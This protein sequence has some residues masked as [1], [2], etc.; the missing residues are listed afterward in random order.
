MRISRVIVSSDS[1]RDY[2]EFWPIVARTWSL[3]GVTPTLAYTDADDSVV[4]YSVGDVVRIPCIKGVDSVFAAQCARLLVPA[5]YPD[6][7]CLISDID[8]LPLSIDFFQ[9]PIASLKDESF[10]IYRSRACP[11][12]QIAVCWNAALGATWGEMFAVGNMDD[13]VRTLME[14]TPAVYRFAGAGW[15]TDQ[16]MLRRYVERFRETN[17]ARV[18]ELDDLQTGFRRL[19]RLADDQDHSTRFEMGKFYSDF[20]MPRP[21]SE[22]KGLINAVVGLHFR[23]RIKPSRR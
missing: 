21:Y 22:H 2:I 10:V 16:V 7:V 4:D 1:N 18:I 12:D 5:F 9:S 14:W 19:D 3:L 11:A 15:F 20:H 6:D 23:D 17:A 8:D 13:L